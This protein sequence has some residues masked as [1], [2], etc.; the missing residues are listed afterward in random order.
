[1]SQDKFARTSRSMGMGG[2]GLSQSKF[3]HPELLP[4][5]A[6]IQ[7]EVLIKDQED[8]KAMLTREILNAYHMVSSFAPLACGH[9]RQHAGSQNAEDRKTRRAVP[10]IPLCTVTQTDQLLCCPV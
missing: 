7:Y 2:E 3:D 8:Q 10:D 9:R 1:M 5:F 6:S 4:N